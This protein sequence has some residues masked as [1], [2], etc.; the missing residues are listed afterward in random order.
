MSFRRRTWYKNLR[1]IETNPTRDDVFDSIESYRAAD[2]RERGVIA[3]FFVFLGEVFSGWRNSKARVALRGLENYTKDLEMEIAFLRS[4]VD[5]QAHNA[6]Q[7]K[8]K[9]K[10]YSEFRRQTY[11]KSS[12]VQLERPN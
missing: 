8:E 11:L 4:S 7:Q 12:R 5:A 9:R 10:R 2:E 3:S 1:E 6:E